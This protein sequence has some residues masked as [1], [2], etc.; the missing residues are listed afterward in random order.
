MRRSHYKFEAQRHC[1]WS[2]AHEPANQCQRR[3]R[4]ATQAHDHGAGGIA[5]FPH[6]CAGPK[7]VLEA[8]PLERK[9]GALDAAPMEPI[10]RRS[11]TCAGSLS[12]LANLC[13]ASDLRGKAGHAH[14]VIVQPALASGWRKVLTLRRAQDASPGA[15]RTRLAYLSTRTGDG[16]DVPASPLAQSSDSI[17]SC[18]VRYLGAVVRKGDF[19]ARMPSR[20]GAIQMP[21][22]MDLIETSTG[23]PSLPVAPTMK[24]FRPIFFSDVDTERYR[25]TRRANARVCALA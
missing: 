1:G 5:K 18:D 3:G 17:G 7:R 2:R 15:P 11:F 4:H 10:H 16:R 19:G 22:W 24:R 6:A 13:L 14:C 23:A 21:A 25:H 12:R 9:A 8:R 20:K